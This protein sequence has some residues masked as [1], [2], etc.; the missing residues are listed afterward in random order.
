MIKD[1]LSIEYIQKVLEPENASRLSGIDLFDSIDSTHTYLLKKAKQGAPSG[2]VCLAEEQTAGRG[3]F[4]KSWYSPHG[5]N[6]YCS[7][8]WRFQASTQDV[9]G[10]GIAVGVMVVNALRRYGVTTAVQLKWPNDVLAMN[11][12]LAGILLERDHKA[13]VVIGVGLNVDVRAAGEKTWID[14]SELTDQPVQRNALAGTLLNEMLGQL[15]RFE[16][17]GLAPFL[18]AWKEHD[19]LLDRPILV[20]TPGHKK[21]GIMRGITGSGELRLEDENGIQC[22]R[23]GEVSIR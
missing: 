6:I 7:L 1:P 11:R 4:G 19:A 10:L 23:Y 16:R 15:P 5:T 21:A 18:S 8:L 3:R 20:V 13:G 9:S 14:L 12:K 17:D 2:F 22:F